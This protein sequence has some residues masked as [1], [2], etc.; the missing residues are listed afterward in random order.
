MWP[1]ENMEALIGGVRYRVRG[2]QVL[3]HDHY[4]DG[5][6]WDRGGRNTFLFRSPKGRYFAVYLT[7][8]QGERD[9]IEA[10]TPEMAL[11]LYER[12]P[13]KEVPPE[14]AFPMFVIEEA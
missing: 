8:W 13:E 2:S 4:W 12:L 1:D 6:N 7:R 3:A 5:R 9:R 11:D 10:L 14:E